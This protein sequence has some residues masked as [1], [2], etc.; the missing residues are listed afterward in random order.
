MSK[1]HGR[2][3]GPGK[4]P[5]QVHLTADEIALLDALAAQLSQCALGIYVSRAEAMK[6]AAL[7]WIT[8]Q[9]AVPGLR[10]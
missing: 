4:K 3:P 9:H 7:A 10:D 2:P 1:F 8:Q 5:L 6:R